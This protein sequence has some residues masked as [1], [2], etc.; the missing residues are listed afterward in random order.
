MKKLLHADASMAPRD[1]PSVVREALGWQ[2]VFSSS[3]ESEV[4]C[5]VELESGR[6]CEWLVRALPNDHHSKGNPRSDLSVLEA[7][8]D[9]IPRYKVSDDPREL[10]SRVAHRSASASS[11]H[12]C[13]LRGIIELPALHQSLAVFDYE[14]H[15]LQDIFKYNQHV[16]DDD[17]IPDLAVSD[18]KRRLLVYQLLR[19]V[20]LLHDRGL[21]LGGISPSE[22][23]VVALTHPDPA[24][25]SHALQHISHDMSNLKVADDRLPGI[26]S[27]WEQSTRG[28][29]ANMEGPVGSEKILYATATGVFAGS[30]IGAVESV[31]S[32]PKL[33]A[34][35]PKF[36][37]QVKHIGS[38]ALVLGA[39]AGFFATGEQVMATVRQKEDPFN[40]AFGGAVAGLVPGILSKNARVAFASSFIA[41]TAMAASSY[42]SEST[43]ETAF[44]KFAKA[45]AHERS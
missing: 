14:P 36:S 42:W 16:L 1:L 19:L 8:Y 3:D 34:K 20:R 12:L 45:R 25:R 31:W 39:A 13:P 41:A 9:D 28:H 4:R 27:G 17:E 7:L 44:E 30:A 6:V 5:L 40:A 21:V 26:I 43:T 32:I 29:K 15:T 24:H 37:T 35:L 23:L 11:V 10:A 33:G 38:R 2:S 22:E 18:M